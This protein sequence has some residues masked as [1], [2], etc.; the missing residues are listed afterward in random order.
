MDNLM[1]L[2]KRT[3]EDD[4]EL[5]ED[6]L[7]TAK[8]AILSR[9]YPYQDFPTGDCG[10][11]KLETRYYDLQYRCALD[12]YNKMGAEGQLGHSSNGIN[13]TYESSWISAQ[14]LAEVTPL[15]GVTT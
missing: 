8:V 7:E 11:F 4:E 2:K 12:M 14:L 10:G 5:L 15:A 13:R 1:R 6:L 9:R 3:G